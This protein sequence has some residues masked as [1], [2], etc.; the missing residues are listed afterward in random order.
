[1]PPIVRAVVVPASGV[2][3]LAGGVVVAPAVGAGALLGMLTAAGDLVAPTRRR[4]A[5]VLRP[6]PTETLAAPVAAGGGRL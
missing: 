1:M 5:A 6:R 4:A 3:L 2:G